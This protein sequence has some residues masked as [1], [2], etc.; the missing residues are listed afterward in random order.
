MA[1]EPRR[2]SFTCDSF[3]LRLER[4]HDRQRRC[5]REA[6][7]LGGAQQIDHVEIATATVHIVRS[8]DE[9]FARDTER[10]TGR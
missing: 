7:L 4:V 9:T 6:R 1:S 5:L 8:R 3:E 10:Q 2:K